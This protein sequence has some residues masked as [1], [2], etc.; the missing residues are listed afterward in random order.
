M[1]R[2]R[3]IVPVLMF[4]SVGLGNYRWCWNHLSLSLAV[5]EALLKRLYNAGFRTIGLPELQAHMRGEIHELHD[6]VV[7]TFDDGYL[8]NWVYVAPMLRRYGMRG[9][10]F[11]NPDFV[12]PLDELRPSLDDF[13]R[14]SCSLEDLRPAGFMNWEELRHLEAEGVLDVQSHAM[15]H[16]WHF[17]G[18]RIVGWHL[19]DRYT[20]WPWLAWNARPDRKPFYLVE[21]Q[22]S[23][24]PL[25]HPVFEY[26]PAIVARRFE[27]DDDALRML[28]ERV[29]QFGGPEYFR[30]P[31]W[32]RELRSSVLGMDEQSAFPGQWESEA[33]QLNRIRYEL[34]Q[35]RE[36]IGQMLGKEVRYICWPAGGSDERCELIARECGYGGWTLRSNQE[37]AKRNMPGAEPAGLRRISIDRYV[38]VKGKQCGESGAGFL[39]MQI[40]EHQRSTYFT[41]RAKLYK[42]AALLSSSW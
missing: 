19:G 33:D 14:G 29:A 40:L 3:R 41:A 42:L 26:R 16:T 20:Q 34:G 28:V 31:S 24:V 22:S 30:R 37:P 9:T 5:F 25:G 13:W 23:F 4:H 32:E 8:D 12:D 39:M 15:T 1:K 27:P 11:I 6:A 17:T 35:S 21:D 38:H 18:P 10:V 2:D 36:I 7:L